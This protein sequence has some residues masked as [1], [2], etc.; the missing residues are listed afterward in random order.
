MKLFT[1][2]ASLTL[3]VSMV[4]G[5]ETDANGREVVCNA[6]VNGQKSC[7]YKCDGDEVCPKIIFYRPCNGDDDSPSNS[8]D[9]PP[10]PLPSPEWVCNPCVNGEQICHPNCPPGRQCIQIVRAQKC[11]ANA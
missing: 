11:T 8:E 6:C 2:L 5:A 7:Y 9:V 3:L 4:A 10:M 1:A